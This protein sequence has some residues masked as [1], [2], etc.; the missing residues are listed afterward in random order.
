MRLIRLTVLPLLI[1]ISTLVHV[2]PLFAVAGLVAQD[3]AAG[4]VPKVPAQA[5]K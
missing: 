3:L 2:L 5:C 4:I 1:A